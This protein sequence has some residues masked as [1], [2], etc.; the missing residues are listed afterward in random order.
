MRSCIFYTGWLW[1]V[2]L[3]LTPR[4]Q[5]FASV[6]APSHQAPTVR[7]MPPHQPPLCCKPAAAPP[8][9]FCHEMPHRVTGERLLTYS[10][11][12][13]SGQ[14]FFTAF[15][16]VFVSLCAIGSVRWVTSLQLLRFCNLELGFNSGSVVVETGQQDW[17]G[18]TLIQH[19]S[20]KVHGTSIHFRI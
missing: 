18:L 16:S 13:N 3:P 20:S 6:V 7:G 2:A 4:V 10:L 12:S 11:T 19:V 17:L 15:P 14:L 5:T 9:Q 1:S 8:P